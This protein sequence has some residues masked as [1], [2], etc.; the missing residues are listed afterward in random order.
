MLQKHPETPTVAYDAL[1]VLGASVWPGGQPG[2]HLL[3]R[4]LHVVELLQRGCAGYLLV[5]GGLG[6][7]LPSEAAV[8][9]RLAVAHGIPPQHVLCEDQAVSTFESAL[10]CCYR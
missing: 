4:I 5:T 1:L 3:R 10:L 6:K 2:P 9:Q 8:M 7:Y